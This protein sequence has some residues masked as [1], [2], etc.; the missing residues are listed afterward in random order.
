[1]LWS[2]M[3]RD[4]ACIESHGGHFEH[5]YK[6]ALSSIAHK[7]NVTRTHVDMLTFACGNGTSAQCLSALFS[8][9][10]YMHGS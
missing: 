5:L 2:I 3:R 8:Y 6:S 9:T 4:E 1:M 7:R 10:L